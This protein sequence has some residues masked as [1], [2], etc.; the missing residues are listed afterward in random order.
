MKISR[1]VRIG[2]LVTVSILIFFIGFNF[3]KNARVLSGDNEYYCYYSN[4]D[5]LQNSASV[6]IRG[7]NVGHVTA[8]KLEDSRVRV[9]LTVSKDIAL[10]VG[11]VASLESLDLLGTKAIRLDAGRGPGIIANKS[12]L[13]SN[14]EGGIMDNVSA[15]LT[16]RLREL[17]TTI[18]SFDSTLASV[19]A[20]VGPDN[21]EN[22][23]AAIRSIKVTADNLSAITGTLKQESGQIASIMHNANSFTANLARNN[24]T[25]S[26]AMAHLNN[27]T[28]Q[29]DHGNVQ[30]T[31]TDLRGAVSHL[32][33]VVDKINRNEGSL[34]MLINNKDLYNNL[35]STLASMGKLMDDIKAHPSRYINVNLIGGRRKD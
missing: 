10:P 18:A 30:Q 15:E 2:I 9:T 3:L 11:T 19:N 13:I 21:R 23:S 1:E 25:I 12:Q 22:I 20:I 5:G 8:M 24:D 31:L 34:G 26:K 4:V 27:F 28:R 17:K 33:Q 16:P 6:Q 29:L 35:T 7:M 32:N 14:K